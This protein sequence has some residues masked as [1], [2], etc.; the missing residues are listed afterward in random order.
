MIITARFAISQEGAASLKVLAKGLLTSANSI[1]ESSAALERCTTG[2]S[3]GLGIYSD[4]I[5]NII[6]RN[7]IT[8]QMNRDDIIGLAK[9]ISDK[10]NDILGLLDLGLGEA[11]SGNSNLGISSAGVNS[12]EPNRKAPRDLPV[13]QY[14]FSQ[15]VDGNLVYDSP[16]EINQ[17][18]YTTQGSANPDFQGTCGLC[19]CANILRLAGVN[20]SEADM[21]AFA[22]V[23]NASGIFPGKLC[24]T[25]YPDPGMNGGTSP[26]SRREILEHFGIDSG[27]L[28]LVRDRDGTIGQNAIQQI[29]DNV[30]S[31]RGTILSVHADILWD[32]AAVGIDDYH[33][34]TVTSVKKDATGNV[35]GFYICDSAMGGT[36]YYPAEKIRRSLTGAPMNVTYQIIR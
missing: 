26:S 24:A 20:L 18:L 19:S 1:I 25:G 31:G 33:A 34:V 7:R 30:A 11:G 2:L 27:V 21:I 14:G 5:I 13:S 23:T 3:D 12:L 16:N 6:T 15:D 35:L 29:A 4:E 17:Y 32:N 28:T 8:L 10:A 9:K 22:S 36:T